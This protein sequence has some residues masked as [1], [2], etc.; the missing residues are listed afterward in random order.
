VR[1]I[2]VRVARALLDA[3]GAGL[4]HRDVSA[5]NV[6]VGDDPAFDDV[7]GLKTREALME[8]CF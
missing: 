4:L 8:S 6:M 7:D 3:H 5:T 1:A 2:A